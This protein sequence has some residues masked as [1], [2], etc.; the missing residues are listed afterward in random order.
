M[1][2]GQFSRVRTFHDFQGGMGDVTWGTG[3]VDLGDGLGMV[4]VNEGTI[5]TVA[6]EANG[7]VQFLTDT[8]DND[9]VALYAGQYSIDNG[10]AVIEARFKVADD[11]GVGLFVG[12]T[13]TLALDTPVMPAEFATT[14]MT[15]NGSGGMV[16]A[17][18]DDDGTTDGWR[19]VMGDGGAAISDSGNGILSDAA[20]PS[21]DT[22][23]L[24]RVEVYSNGGGQV[25]VDEKVIKKFD[26]GTLLTPTDN[27]YAVVMCENR[28]A[29][30]REF[31][32][33]YFFSEGHRDWTA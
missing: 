23:Q 33:D 27:F 6:D 11:L 13:E 17:Q 15:Y 10:G 2:Q 31:E 3:E 1:P 5:N 24:V 8:G 16:G 28:T 25:S 26:T 7:V 9:N 29:A 20:A 14:T 21:A 32:I 12:F 4:S 18:Y 22:Y 19:A 30:A